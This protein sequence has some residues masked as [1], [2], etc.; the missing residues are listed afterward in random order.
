M[1]PQIFAPL[2][3]PWGR[4]LLLSW[5]DSFLPFLRS[6]HRI[7][8]MVLPYEHKKTD[9]FIEKLINFKCFSTI[10][11]THLYICLSLHPSI[12]PSILPS[13][14]P[15]VHTS[16]LLN[17]IYSFIHPTICPSIHPTI[18]PSVRPS[19]CPSIHP[20]IHPSIRPSIHPSIHPSIY[21]WLYS[22]FV[23]SWRFFFQI[24]NPIHSR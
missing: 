12:R 19:I 13:I 17:I 16:I 22:P 15:S 24:L 20:S 14:H 7:R 23:E 4:I 11:M 9:D 6:P 2:H 10:Y 3:F 1:S 21:L 8:P 5:G 18:H